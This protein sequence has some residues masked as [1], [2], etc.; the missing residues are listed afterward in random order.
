VSDK[1]KKILIDITP[2]TGA[3][4]I[5]RYLGLTDKP[6][7]IVAFD[8]AT[9]FK[10][11]FIKPSTRQHWPCTGRPEWL[12]DDMLR[13]PVTPAQACEVL[14]SAAHDS[15]L[16]DPGENLRRL[17]AELADKYRHE[18]RELEADIV[19]SAV[20]LYG[21]DIRQLHQQIHPDRTVYLVAGKPLVAVWR[22]SLINGETFTPHR[23]MDVEPGPM[24]FGM[25]YKLLYTPETKS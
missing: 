15:K 13:F 11:T 16:P 4:D 7:K 19:L 8:E 3:N 18:V 23:W 22:P 10:R 17:F 20:E 25:K 6:A 2:K 9:P 12:K 21:V 14:H 24:R 5:D 1:P